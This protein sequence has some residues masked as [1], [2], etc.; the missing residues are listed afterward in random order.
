MTQPSVWNATSGKL[1]MGWL[2]LFPQKQSRL[3]LLPR[4]LL[5]SC[6]PTVGNTKWRTPVFKRGSWSLS[7]QYYS[8]AVFL[9]LTWQ[10]RIWKQQG[11]CN[12][13]KIFACAQWT[14]K[15]FWKRAFWQISQAWMDPQ[16]G[17]DD[18]VLIAEIASFQALLQSPNPFSISDLRPPSAEEKKYLEASEK[19]R[20]WSMWFCSMSLTTPAVS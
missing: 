15:Q 7:C 18:P 2:L 5:H 17:S 16:G 14:R 8:A 11:F 20:P 4:Q 9:S 6:R 3:V 19:D 10:W 1:L 13:W 12:S